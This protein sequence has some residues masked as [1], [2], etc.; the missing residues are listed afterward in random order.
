VE[1]LTTEQM[2]KADR[3]AIDEM[4]IPSLELMENAG[5]MVAEEI[6]AK[7]DDYIDLSVVVVCGKGNN[8]G[9]GF[10]V[11]RHLEEMGIGVQ[12]FM[13]DGPEELKGDA[14]VNYNRAV[15]VGIKI[16]RV[17]DIYDFNI[18]D[19]TDVIVDALFGTGF[20]GNIRGIAADMVRRM[21]EFSVPIVSV[22]C[23]SGLDTTT[24]EVSDPCVIADYTV[25]L[26]RPK[27]GLYLYPGRDFAGEISI[28][29]IGIPD[30]AVEKVSDRLF[31]I[32]PDYLL[33]NLP[34]RPSDGYK[35]TF[36][37]LYVL[38][39]SV[40][41][42]GAA[43]LSSESA[44][45]AGCGMVRLGCPESLNDIL[46]V[47]LTEVMTDPLPEVRRKRCLALRALGE[48]RKY[49]SDWA[50]AA[51]IGPGIGTHFET[52][53]LI[54]RLIPGLGVPAVIDADGLNNLA[55]ADDIFRQIDY[56]CV[57][58]PH[59]GELARLTGK[60]IDEITADRF[61][62]L[63]EATARFGVVIVYKGPPMF[64]GNPDGDI[65]VNPTGNSGMG[66]AGTG[67]VLTG[68]IGSFLAQGMDAFPAAVCGTYI[69]GAAGDLALDLTGNRG[70]TAGDVRDFVSEA[71]LE[72][73]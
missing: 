53:E 48:I 9:D 40:G 17:D 30:E 65:F 19:G 39:G 45:R 67:D 18:P 70:M 52:K 15:G 63:R 66:T 44:L 54:R 46:E 10:V 28:V 50:D 59:A 64:I 1:L 35:G 13:I 4:G 12:C 55:E 41:L 20:K 24:G 42:T 22:D 36:G 61:A 57:L 3:H 34:E 60:S 62:T 33:E 32:T 8:G 37:M 5:A 25:T 47:K 31:L 38:A 14:A 43:A 29:D 7:F 23:P 26:A 21:N 11:A 2:Q 56:P 71:L 73:E 27:L 6:T 16:T 49:I 51:A 68:I 72:F 58:T 69:V